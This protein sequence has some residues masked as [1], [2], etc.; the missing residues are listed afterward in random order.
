MFAYSHGSVR[1]LNCMNPRSG[2]RILS[3]VG[4]KL[5]VTGAPCPNA[6]AAVI[7]S[8]ITGKIR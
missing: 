2:L 7:P 6:E 3:V 1:K 8:T 5:V 4:E